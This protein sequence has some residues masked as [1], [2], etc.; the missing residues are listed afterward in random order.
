MVDPVI[1]VSEG[2]CISEEVERALFDA[3]DDPMDITV[4]VDCEEDQEHKPALLPLR[5]ELEPDLRRAWS[6]ISDLPIERV[7][8]HYLGPKVNAE[9]CIAHNESVEVETLRQYEQQLRD[10]YDA[11]DQIDSINLVLSVGEGA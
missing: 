8:L 5:D 4:H 7:T 3:L 2:H 6:K 10:E 1:S 11:N 9:I